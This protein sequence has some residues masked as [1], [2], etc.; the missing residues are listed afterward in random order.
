M[1]PAPQAD[2]AVQTSAQGQNPGIVP[3]SVLQLQWFSFYCAAGGFAHPGDEKEAAEEEHRVGLSSK[4]GLGRL[5]FDIVFIS[6]QQKEASPNGSLTEGLL[7]H[8]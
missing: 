8:R 4:Q 1:R 5:C 7:L 2:L 6:R 3:P